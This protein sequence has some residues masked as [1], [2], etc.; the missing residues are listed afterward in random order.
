MAFYFPWF[1]SSLWPQVHEHHSRIC[2]GLGVVF[3]CVLDFNLTY[4]GLAQLE[5]ERGGGA[6]AVALPLPQG[7]FAGQRGLDLEVSREGPNTAGF[8]TWWTHSLLN[9]WFASLCLCSVQLGESNT[10]HKCCFLSLNCTI[11][12]FSPK[13]LWES[14]MLGSDWAGKCLAY[15]FNIC[16]EK[17]FVFRTT[18]KGYF[19]S[20]TH[21]QFTE[22]RCVFMMNL[23]INNVDPQLCIPIKDPKLGKEHVNFPMTVKF[24]YSKYLYTEK[25]LA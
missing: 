14:L 19:Y 6:Q 9:A 22:W 4:A 3:L 25:A 21:L 5:G 13:L 24:I 8:W 11:L 16:W 20:L 12:L 2:L 7:T 17:S 18:S 23:P 15:L 10:P 1:P